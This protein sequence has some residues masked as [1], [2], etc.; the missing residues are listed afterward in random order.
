[1]RNINLLI[2]IFLIFAGMLSFPRLSTITAMTNAQAETQRMEPGRVVERELKGGE[3]H[4]YQVEMEAGQFLHAVVDQRGI[5]VV[6]IVFAPNGQKVFEVDSP[7]GASGPESVY[8]LGETPGPY[9]L[10]TSNKIGRAH[11]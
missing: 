7:N 11:V 10:S 6:V 4:Q 8:L 3:V 9:R 2:V 5:D 1:M